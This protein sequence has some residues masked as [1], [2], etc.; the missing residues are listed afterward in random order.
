M[1]V[2]TTGALREL[3]NL[4]NH[5]QRRGA[6]TLFAVSVGG[7]LFEMLGVGLVVPAFT[8]LSDANAAVRFPLLAPMLERLGNPT[9]A[10][11]VAAAM[12]L[13]IAVYLVKELYLALLAWLQMRY[14]Y[15]VQA[16]LSHRMYERYLS[17]SYHFHLGR[18]SAQLIRNAITETNLF[19]Q[20]VLTAGL[21]VLTE[22]LIG[23]GI[24]AVMLYVEAVGTLLVLSMMG[25]AIAA[26]HRMT[27][28]RISGWGATRQ[29]SEGSRI[30]HIQQGLGGIKEVKLMHRESV[31][32][33][34]F[35]GANSVYAAA[36]RRYGFIAQLPRL[37]LEFLGV[38]GLALFVL[39]M[40]GGG[41]TP[42]AVMSTLGAFAVGAFR[43]LPSAN[44]VFS[45]VQSVRYG[46]PV[47]GV[48]ASELAESPSSQAPLPPPPFPTAGSITLDNVVFQYAET[49]APSVANVSLTIPRGSTTGIV[50]TTGSG[51]T[52]LIDVILGLLPPT[53]GR[54]LVSGVDIATNLAGWQR[55]I[56]YVPQ[57]V[58]LTDESLRQNIAFGVRPA[59][60]DAARIQQVLEF[61]Q[62]DEF[63]AG[64]PEKLDTMVGERGVRLSG[65]QRQ[66][67]G[68]ARAL[69]NDPTVLVLDEATS[70]LDTVTE[71]EVLSSL[72]TFNGVKT[73]L[74]IAHRPQALAHC[75]RILRIENGRLSEQKAQV[76]F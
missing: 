33:S 36:C 60:I 55:Q 50:G 34:A 16:E 28:T 56:G 9:H 53:S 31:F 63:V 70:A 40:I 29:T 26:F 76:A 24:I 42:D 62:L 2:T 15:S 61:A 41:Q 38:A 64:L 74:V 73:V 8:L 54:V 27:A 30:Q 23:I 57:T 37:W 59:E 67:I 1:T 4:L 58:Y 46:M 49:E 43:L 11:I 72:G 10:K 20:V 22:V 35:D 3:W 32:L 68:I 19:S 66:R 52:T 12:V 39:V 25:V 18:N 7:M 48:L 71:S 17:Q 65:G 51:K 21:Q 45:G 69:Y 13:L 6:I 44:R 14:I 75:D 47:I 5:R